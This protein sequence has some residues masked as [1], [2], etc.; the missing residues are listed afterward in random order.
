VQQRQVMAAVHPVL[1]ADAFELPEAGRHAR[2]RHA[3]ER[4]HARVGGQDRGDGRGGPLDAS[5]RHQNA[6]R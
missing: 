5:G 2:L 1:P 6:C 4:A 3:L